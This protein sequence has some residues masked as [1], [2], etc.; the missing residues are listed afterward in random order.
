MGPSRSL[1]LGGGRVQSMECRALEFRALER[2]RLVCQ[3][4]GE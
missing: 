1:L 4:I 2:N 3:G